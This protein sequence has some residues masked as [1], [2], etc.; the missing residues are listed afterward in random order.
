VIIFG[1]KKKALLKVSMRFAP[2]PQNPGKPQAQTSPFVW[3]KENDV[4]GDFRVARIEK[5]V[6]VLERGGRVYNLSLYRPGKAPG[7]SM[8]V[9]AE[10]PP[11]A[12]PA[13]IAE[14]PPIPRLDQPLPEPPKPT[15]QLS[16]SF[17]AP[18]QR[19]PRARP[20]GG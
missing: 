2:M 9:Y 8:P 11:Q 19:Q 18:R 6:I 16:N 7:E 1:P 14:A 3:V 12:E 10:Q 5:K 13:Q 20:S 4:V 15:R 17:Q